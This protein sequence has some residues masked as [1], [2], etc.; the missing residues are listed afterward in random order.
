MGSRAAA[1]PSQSQGPLYRQQ[2]GIQRSH[3]S[4]SFG[5]LSI[6][7]HPHLFDIFPLIYTILFFFNKLYEY[8]HQSSFANV[9][10]VV[11]HG[12]LVWNYQQ[13]KNI[14]ELSLDLS[15]IFYPHKCDQL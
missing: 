1:V 9:H 8:Y 12:S 15:E 4:L 7:S 10:C 5:M 11:L 2:L 13:R 6:G 14:E 3:Q